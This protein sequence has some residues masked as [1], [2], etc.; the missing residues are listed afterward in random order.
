MYRSTRGFAEKLYREG[1]AAEGW[2][3]RLALCFAAPTFVLW[4][5][6]VLRFAVRAFFRRFDFRRSPA[7]LP[8]ARWRAGGYRVPATESRRFGAV[9]KADRQTS[10]PAVVRDSQSNLPAA[11]A[12]RIQTPPHRHRHAE[13]LD[14][15]GCCATDG[16]RRKENGGCTPRYWPAPRRSRPSASTFHIEQAALASPLRHL[17]AVKTNSNNRSKILRRECT[18]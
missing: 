6:A 14:P 10:L 18:Q 5:F 1:R 12:D 11:R 4:S 16:T 17:S 2:Q 15:A 13:H 3:P 8:R 9:A 7:E